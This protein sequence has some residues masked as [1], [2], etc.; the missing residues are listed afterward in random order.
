MRD[1]DPVLRVGTDDKR[2]GMDSPPRISDDSRILT[3]AK[4]GK[5]PS[6]SFLAKGW[7]G[8]GDH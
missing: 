6:G 5:A 3:R 7:D 4:V 1:D 2:E 8:F